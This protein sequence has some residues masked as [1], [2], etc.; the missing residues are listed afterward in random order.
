MKTNKNK[1]IFLAGI[2]QGSL[3]D[4]IADQDYRTKLKDMFRKYMPDWDIYSPMDDHSD[5]LDYPEEKGK[6]IFFYHIE[7]AAEADL[8]VCYIPTA[9]MGTAVEMYEAHKRNKPIVTIS[10]L[11]KNWTIKFLSTYIF[12]TI[13]ELEDYFSQGSTFEI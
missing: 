3:P 11:K 5:S 2:I 8:L 1:T 7:K 10:P 13:Q 9:S 12:E 4:T 6:D